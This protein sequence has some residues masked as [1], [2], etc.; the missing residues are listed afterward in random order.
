MVCGAAVLAAL[1]CSPA[2]AAGP[3][4]YMAGAYAG[5]VAQT[6]PHPYAGS[7]GFS[8]QPGALTALRFKVTMV[9][10]HQ[11][12]AQVVSPPNHLKIRITHAGRFSYRGKVHGASMRLKGRIYGRR[13]RGVFFDSFHMSKTSTC[14][15]FS[16]ARFGA[17]L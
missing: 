6:V 14:T 7:I 10:G 1:G 13:V 12:L 3:V 17:R 5:K 11:L 2:L 16:P 4:A 8:I 9:C 15:M